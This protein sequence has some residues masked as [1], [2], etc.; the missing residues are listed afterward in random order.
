MIGKAS[1]SSPTNRSD[2]LIARQVYFLEVKLARPLECL[3]PMPDLGKDHV[4]KTRPTPEYGLFYSIAHHPTM[5]LYNFYLTNLGYKSNLLNR[6][7]FWTPIKGL[8]I[9]KL[10]SPDWPISSGV[11]DGAILLGFPT[12]GYAGYRIHTEKDPK[13]HDFLFKEG[14][15]MITPRL[16]LGHDYVTC[17]ASRPRI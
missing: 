12:T 3:Q 9:R 15:L 7:Q 14:Y 8:S 2:T 6:P 17:M 5:W 4:D 11:I 16:R 10:P 13:V 1:Q